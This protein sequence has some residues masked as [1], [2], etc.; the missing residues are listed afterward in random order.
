MFLRGHR[1]PSTT[2]FF[3]YDRTSSGS[4]YHERMLRRKARSRLIVAVSVVLAAAIALVCVFV[5]F[6]R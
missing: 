4:T 1:N 3:D 5:A 2:G 6:T